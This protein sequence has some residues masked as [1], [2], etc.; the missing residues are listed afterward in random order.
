MYLPHCTRES[1]I[2]P[3]QH[4]YQT[5]ARLRMVAG[6]LTVKTFRR[7]LIGETPFHFRLLDA[8][9]LEDHTEHDYGSGC[10]AVGRVPR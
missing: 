10:V 8:N 5:K 9:R 4:V 1:R 2:V 7:G 6:D 3:S